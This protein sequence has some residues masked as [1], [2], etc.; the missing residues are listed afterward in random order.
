LRSYKFSEDPDGVGMEVLA[1]D[2]EALFKAAG[3]ALCLYM[4][5]QDTVNV[6]AEIPVCRTAL[7]LRTAVAGILTELLFQTEV[8]GWVLKGFEV[9]SVHTLPESDDGREHIQV[10]GVALGEHFD[11]NRHRVRFPVRAV[12][13]RKLTYTESDDGVRFYCLLDA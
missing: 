3:D 5:D 10:T 9:H 12:L 4:W 1:P 6:M 2:R 8:E 11:P 13:L 7:N